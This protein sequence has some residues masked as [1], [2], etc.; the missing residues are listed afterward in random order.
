[1][2]R[3]LLA[4]L[5]L[6]AAPAL[7]ASQSSAPWHLDRVDQRQLPL[8]GTY[9]YGP[10]GQGVT[11]YV[12][13]TGVRLSSTDLTGRVTTGVD[14]V[15]GGAADDCNGHGTHVAG[16][17]GG[18][19]FGVAKRVRVVAVRVLDCEG[20]GSRSTVLAGLR[21]VEQ[22]HARPAVV[23]LSLG[24]APDPALDTVVRQLVRE[25]VVVVTAAGNDGGDACAG[26]PSRTGVA[27]TVSATDRRD[28]VP[29][30]ADTGRCV[31]LFAPGVAV[32]SDWWDGRTR[33]I[34]GTSMAAPLVAGAAAVWLERH[35]T[36]TPAQVRQAL[37][38][39]ATPRVVVG[40][41]DA[42]DRLLRVPLTRG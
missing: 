38:Y 2:R 26:S 34:S 4:V 20:R 7:A 42:P 11:A 10:T 28:H 13:D 15:D 39:A 6:L 21:W 5:L 22:H 33:T 30:W 25:G 23:N 16:L 27:L 32:T 9:R 17:L 40:R 3:L 37:V 19:R 18:T 35:P 31:D 41:G 24:G 12:V 29:S 8:D 14:L 1:M 36:A